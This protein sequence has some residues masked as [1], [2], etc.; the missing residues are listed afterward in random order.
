MAHAGVKVKNAYL[1]ALYRNL[2]GRLVP[3]KAII[4]IVHRIIRAVHHML[5]NR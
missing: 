1:G 2:V 3:K 4:A 5:P